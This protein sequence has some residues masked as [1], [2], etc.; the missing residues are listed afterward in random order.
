M[1]LTVPNLI[2]RAVTVGGPGAGN[3]DRFVPEI[4]DTILQYGPNINPLTIISR[5]S[6]KESVGNQEYK[7][8]N[9]KHL[10]RLTR[11]NNGGGY[12]TTD[13]SIVVDNGNYAAPQMV[14]EVT[15]TGEHMLV[16]AVSSNTWTV[17]RGYDVGGAGTG[18]AIVDNDEIRILGFAGAERSGA[19]TSIQTSPGTVLN[20]A[21][22][23][24]RAVNLSKIRENTEEYGMKEHARQTKNTMY[25]FKVDVE[26]AFLFGKPLKDVEGSSPL[27]GSLADTRYKTG[28][29]KYWI[30]N[31]ASQNILDANGVIT[32]TAL[33]DFLAPLYKYHPDDTTGQ[34]MELTALCGPKA[35][36]AF[37]SWAV[38]RIDTSVDTKKYGLQLTTYQ[39]PVGRINLVQHYMLEGDEYSDYMFIVNPR[40]LSYKYLQKMDL[41]VD[42]D[43]Q[44]PGVLERKDMMYGVIGLGIGRPELHGYIKNMQAAA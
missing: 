29:L 39:A 6:K 2:N 25:E 4:A 20:Y 41:T 37:H 12:N 36:H 28:G 22:L 40:D 11:V 23:H 8:M 26:S 13:A 24:L 44:T 34:G 5:Q 31:Y 1:A 43:V 18:V 17:E 21:Q 15:R 32:Q 14:V 30:D 9:D 10:P 3:T 35:F 27:D 7:I 19:P 33:W 42:T 16:T 38:A